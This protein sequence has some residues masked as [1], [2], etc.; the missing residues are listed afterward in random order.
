VITATAPDGACVDINAWET[1]SCRRITVEIVGAHY[2]GA[3]VVL[4]IH[5]ISL[6]YYQKYN[7]NYN[8]GSFADSNILPKRK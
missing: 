4:P 1:A 2:S 8:L 7:P 5:P 3:I 6:R